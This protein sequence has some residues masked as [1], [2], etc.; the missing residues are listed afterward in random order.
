MIT[1]VASFEEFAAAN[2]TVKGP[3]VNGFQN[4]YSGNSTHLASRRPSYPRNCALPHTEMPASCQVALT[5]RED[6]NV[7]SLDDPKAHH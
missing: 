7:P 6:Y 4:S 2:F 1:S 3:G 5:Y